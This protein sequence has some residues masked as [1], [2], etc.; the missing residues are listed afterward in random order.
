MMVA[1][2]GVM[3]LST[4][5]ERRKWKPE[6]VYAYGA[7]LFVLAAK[8]PRKSALKNTH[9]KFRSYFSPSYHLSFFVLFMMMML[10]VF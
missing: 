9:S 7:S 5:Y 6:N 10:R 3:I 2:M 8:K 4:I 1:V